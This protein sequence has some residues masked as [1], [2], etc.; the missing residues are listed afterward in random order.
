METNMIEGDLVLIIGY[1]D[2]TFANCGRNGTIIGFFGKKIG[3]LLEN[4]Q[5]FIGQPYDFVKEENVD[6][7]ST[8]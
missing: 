3:V 5:I 1:M 2:K 4:G 7:D 6:K 8:K